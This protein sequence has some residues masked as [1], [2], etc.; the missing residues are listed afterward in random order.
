MEWPIVLGFGEGPP[1]P[2]ESWVRGMMEQSRDHQFSKPGRFHAYN[3]SLRLE[4][5]SKNRS[6]DCLKGDLEKIWNEG[7]WGIQRK[8]MRCPLG[9]SL[10]MLRLPEDT[11]D[12]CVAGS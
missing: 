9:A 11:L 3:L 5:V 1:P 7:D 10:A 12:R 6:A 4:E 2:C 8:S